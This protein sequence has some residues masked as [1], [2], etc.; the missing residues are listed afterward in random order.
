MPSPRNRVARRGANTVGAMRNGANR[1]SYE[2]AN[3]AARNLDQLARQGREG[4]GSFMRQ[5]D[6]NRLRT[7]ARQIRSDVSNPGN[8]YREGTREE[9]QAQHRATY[10]NIRRAFGMAAG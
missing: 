10:R 5:A 7:A 4:N 1:S 2:T 3:N 6:K 9:L 8:E